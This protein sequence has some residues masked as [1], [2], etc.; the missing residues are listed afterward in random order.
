[1]SYNCFYCLEYTSIKDHYLLETTITTPLQCK[2]K[3]DNLCN[4]D[5]KNEKTNHSHWYLCILQLKGDFQHIL[6]F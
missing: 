3:W 4:C 6:K 1:M 5:V 2:P